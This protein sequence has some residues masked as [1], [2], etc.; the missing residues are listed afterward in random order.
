M[1][2]SNAFYLLFTLCLLFGACQ[3]EPQSTSTTTADGT[4]VR[5]EKADVTNFA[6]KLAATPNAQLI[7]VRTPQEFNQGHLDNAVNI[8]YHDDFFIEKLQKLDREKPLFVY[9][10]SGGRSGKTCHKLKKMGFK[11][12]YDMEGGYLAWE[13]KE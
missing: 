4:V 6:K 2:K 11:E 7:D 8:N 3:S 1:M 5:S 9:C 12:I 10:Q 13:A